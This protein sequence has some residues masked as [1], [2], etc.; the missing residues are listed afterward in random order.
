LAEAD[1]MTWAEIAEQARVYA[2]RCRT[3]EAYDWLRAGERLLPHLDLA[4]VAAV[5][6]QIA[7]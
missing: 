2:E 3:A 6:A 7:P 1:V 4:G 5:H